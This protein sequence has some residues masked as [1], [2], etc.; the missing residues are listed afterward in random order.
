VGKRAAI[1]T[2]AANGSVEPL[3]ADIDG[4]FLN[5]VPTVNK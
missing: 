5:A 1:N 3:H 2:A 4:R